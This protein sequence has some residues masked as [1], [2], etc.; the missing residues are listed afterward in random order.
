ML[1]LAN[2][3]ERACRQFGDDAAGQAVGLL[4]TR[5]DVAAIGVVRIGQVGVASRAVFYEAEVER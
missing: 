1:Q 2:G 3:L 5:D 4:E